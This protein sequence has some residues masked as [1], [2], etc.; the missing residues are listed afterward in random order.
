MGIYYIDGTFVSASE[1][2]LPV[3]DLAVLRGYGVFDFMR[4]YGGRPFQLKAHV[5]RLRNSAHL[6]GLSC[7]WSLQEIRDIVEETLR[8]NDYSESNIR[9]LITG[10]DSDDSITPGTQPRLLVMISEV[11]TFPVHWYTAGVKIITKDITRFI[12]GAKS[13][14]YIRA[15]LALDDAKAQHAV[16]SLYVDSHDNILEG[17]TS[18]LFVVSDGNVVT[19]AENILPGITR[20]VVLEITTSSFKIALRSVTK[21]ELFRADE[22]FVT[23]SNKE[24]LPVIQVDDQQIGNGKPGKVTVQIMDMFKAYTQEY[25]K[26]IAAE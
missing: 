19:P 21:K 8:R 12:P 26:R 24:I 2:V 6:I 3:S 13:I 5:K 17:T 14:D 20:D 4:T 22:V 16:E 23:S 15:I 9:L 18:N 10:G 7:P 1:A 25:A 11:K